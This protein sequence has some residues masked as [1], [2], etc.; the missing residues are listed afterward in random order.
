M[1]QSSP[2]N[3]LIEF[4]VSDYASSVSYV[5]DSNLFIDDDIYDAVKKLKIDKS[6]GFDL[7]SNE[8]FLYGLCVSPINFLTVYY[9]SII[10][11]GIIPNDFNTSIWQH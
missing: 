5:R 8:F 1:G 7:I 10:L 9:N 6:A 11:T 4:T 3:D 2:H